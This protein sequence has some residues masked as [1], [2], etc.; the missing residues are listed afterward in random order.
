MKKIPAKQLAVGDFVL[1]KLNPVKHSEQRVQAAALKL[2]DLA[3]FEIN[4]VDG[5]LEVTIS[6]FSQ[7]MP[8]ADIARHF[9]NELIDQALRARIAEETAAERNLILSYAF[10]NTR[11]LR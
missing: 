7:S 3:G 1:M 8:A 2:S 4:D 9:S 10:S 11:L 5:Q 6:A